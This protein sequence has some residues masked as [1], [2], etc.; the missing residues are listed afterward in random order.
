MDFNDRVGKSP[1]FTVIDFYIVVILKV[2]L[3]VSLSFV[4]VA[5]EFFSRCLFGF[6][7][8]LCTLYFVNRGETSFFVIHKQKSTLRQRQHASV[9]I[10][11]SLA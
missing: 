2:L 10:A 5:F 8:R 3:F 9:R 1:V 11:L 7:F 4:A 6:V